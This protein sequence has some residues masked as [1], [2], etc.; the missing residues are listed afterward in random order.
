MIDTTDSMSILIAGVKNKCKE[1]SKKSNENNKLQNYDIKHE[2]DFYRDSIDSYLNKHEN[3][4][5]MFFI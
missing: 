2:G 5:K 3:Q 4:K 1:I